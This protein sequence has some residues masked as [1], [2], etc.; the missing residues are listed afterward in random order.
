MLIEC[1]APAVKLS[2]ETLNQIALYNNQFK[3]DYLFIS[4]GLTHLICRFD[5]EL[6]KYFPLENFPNWNSLKLNT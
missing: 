6:N 3:V 2:Q 4:N 1:K 5:K